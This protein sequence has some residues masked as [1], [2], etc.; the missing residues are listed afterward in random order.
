M[1]FTVVL[2]C[3]LWTN[4]TRNECGAIAVKKKEENV[5]YFVASNKRKHLLYTIVCECFKGQLYENT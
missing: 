2:N 1:P 3:E 4:G 5:A